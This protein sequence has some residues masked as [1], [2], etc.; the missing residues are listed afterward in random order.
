MRVLL[1]ED[2]R[3]LASITALNL[4]RHGFVV[5]IAYSGEETLRFLEDKSG[6][7]VVILDLI[8]PDI[9]GTELLQ[10][11][12]AIS[13]NLPVMAL[14]ARDSEEDRVNGIQLGFD[15]YM[16]K[17]FSYL[18]LVSRLKVLSR[19]RH[20]SPPKLIEID[21]LKIYPEGQE[22][23]ND[24]IKVQLT[25]NEFRLLH[26]LVKNRGRVVSSKELLESI[27][28]MNSTE[29]KAKVMTTVSRLR[30]KIGDHQKNIIKTRKGGYIID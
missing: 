30:K 12:K 1:T 16:T 29:T 24:G 5:D 18:E 14:T 4:K 11:L 15:D 28:D 23:F 2:N 21:I 9:D 10:D 13:P 3:E 17:P 7:D 25:L 20:Y 22:V 8:L 19:L 27:W 26:F 6:Y